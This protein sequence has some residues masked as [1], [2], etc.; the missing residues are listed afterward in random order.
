MAFLIIT[1]IVDSL[2]LEETLNAIAASGI[3]SSTVLSG[4]VFM[5]PGGN[6][7][8]YDEID[9][10]SIPDEIFTFDREDVATILTIASTD[11]QVE[12]VIKAVEFLF[13]EGAEGKKH[14]YS[15]IVLHIDWVIGS[16]GF[17][18]SENKSGEK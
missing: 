17:P 16:L 13:T 2:K 6:P 9:I 5:H 1:T 15:Q 12:K 4:Q 14:G 8:L 10:A 7:Q 3:D 18:G 11:E